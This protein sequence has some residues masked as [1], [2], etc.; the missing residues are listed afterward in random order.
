MSLSIFLCFSNIE[1]KYNALDVM[2]QF[3]NAA[4]CRV[5]IG[6]SPEV[7]PFILE[8]YKQARE[9][10][11][12]RTI[13]FQTRYPSTAFL[14]LLW[15]LCSASDDVCR[16]VVRRGGLTELAAALPM[17]PNK[18]VGDV[19]FYWQVLF[20][21][22]SLLHI[23]LAESGRHTQAVLSEPNIFKGVNILNFLWF[24]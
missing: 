10:A 17:D 24:H 12:H 1:I 18:K 23:L 6:D 7:I 15:S 22:N 21:A 16:E 14:Q 4:E 20:A 2:A 13:K 5:L 3:V 9:Q 19:H 8:N 11:D